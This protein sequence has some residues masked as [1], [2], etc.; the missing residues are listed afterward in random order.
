[1]VFLNECFRMARISWR[2]LLHPIERMSVC[3]ASEIYSKDGLFAAGKVLFDRY[4][5]FFFE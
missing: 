1:M 3:N 5:F 4:Y 2:V